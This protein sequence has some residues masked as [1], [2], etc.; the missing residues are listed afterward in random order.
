MD[1]P[2]NSVQKTENL[3]QYPKDP[4]PYKPISLSE[5]SDVV[6][7]VDDDGLILYYNSSSHEEESQPTALQERN[8]ACC[9]REQ[10]KNYI[11]LISTLLGIAVIGSLAFATWRLIHWTLNNY[12]K[13]SV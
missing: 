13:T 5:Q 9:T 10:K 8:V 11:R 1:Y 3:Y 6:L 12:Y 2:L 7:S 4:P